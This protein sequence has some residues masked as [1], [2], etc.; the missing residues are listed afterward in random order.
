MWNLNGT[1]QLSTSG[2]IPQLTRHQRRP[3][4]A[5]YYLNAFAFRCDR[6]RTMANHM[7]E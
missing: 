7:I 5:Y 2:P 3:A 1:E 6:S 4:P